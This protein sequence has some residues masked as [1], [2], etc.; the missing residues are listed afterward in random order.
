[1]SAAGAK[2]MEKPLN[3]SVGNVSHADT[4]INASLKSAN[5]WVGC[6]YYGCRRQD[7]FTAKPN[8]FLMFRNMDAYGRELA[9]RVLTLA[10]SLFE[11]TLCAERSY[12]P[13]F[14]CQCNPG[15]RR[16]G[17]LGCII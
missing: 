1:V 15:C 16:Y 14:R 8:C 5:G 2:E 17:L 7:L 13:E 10:V 6:W 11:L 3:V 4:S 12:H 9:V